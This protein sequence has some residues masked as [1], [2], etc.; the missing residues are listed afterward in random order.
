MGYPYMS[1]LSI[2]SLDDSPDASDIGSLLAFI[3]SQLSTEVTDASA[4]IEVESDSAYGYGYATLTCERAHPR[5]SEQ[6]M[7]S[8]VRLCQQADGPVTANIRSR[9]VTADGEEHPELRAGPPNLLTNMAKNF[10]CVSGGLELSPEATAI[11]ANEVP[12]F[13]KK[14]CQTKTVPCPS[15]LSVN[16][17]EADSCWARNKPRESYWGWREWFTL[18][19]TLLLNIAPRSAPM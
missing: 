5:M 15:W 18:G 14:I 3:Q 19:K 4:D 7:Q 12:D 6:Q 10:D 13:V 8:E 2:D 9:F 16:K 11:K 1:I 17:T